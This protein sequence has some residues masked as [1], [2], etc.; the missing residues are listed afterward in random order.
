MSEPIIVEETRELE[1]VAESPG[2]STADIART[3]TRNDQR[4]G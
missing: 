2:T 3:V 1:M 4:G